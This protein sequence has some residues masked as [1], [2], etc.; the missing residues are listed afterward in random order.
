[1]QCPE[2]KLTAYCYSADVDADTALE[3][4]AGGDDRKNAQVA[5]QSYIDDALINI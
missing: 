5:G 3:G 2:G 4:L 1:M